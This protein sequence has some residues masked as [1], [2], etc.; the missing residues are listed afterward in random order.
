MSRKLEKEKRWRPISSAQPFKGKRNI[1][2]ADGGN[3]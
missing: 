1:V 2:L 3:Y